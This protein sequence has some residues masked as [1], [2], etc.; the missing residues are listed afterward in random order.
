MITCRACGG[1]IQ[2]ADINNPAHCMSC[3]QP[4]FTLNPEPRKVDP[5]KIKKFLADRVKKQ[6]EEQK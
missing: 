6:K 2:A 1:Q 4:R 3:G 5:G